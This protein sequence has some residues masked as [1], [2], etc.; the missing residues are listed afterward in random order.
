MCTALTPCTHDNG[1]RLRPLIVLDADGKYTLLRQPGGQSDPSFSTGN[2]R[3][4]HSCPWISSPARELA[5]DTTWRRELGD[6]F[7]YSKGPPGF[8]SLST[9]GPRFKPGRPKGN[10]GTHR[11]PALYTSVPTP[12]RLAPYGHRLWGGVSIPL[13]RQRHPPPPAYLLVSTR[14]PTTAWG[15][16]RWTAAPVEVEQVGSG[17]RRPNHI[18]S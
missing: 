10:H 2:K 14:T 6:T 11:S 5:L 17:S 7:E 12:S 1:S 15:G 13:N 8:K 3:A 9:T 18:T 4:S 16:D